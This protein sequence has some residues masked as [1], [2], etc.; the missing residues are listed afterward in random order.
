M[1]VVPVHD[2]PKPPD[3]KLRLVVDHSAGPYSL[4]SMI[5]RKSIGGVKFD[6]IKT[7]GDSIRE[8]HASHAD[9]FLSG[10][11]LTLW[12]SDVAAVYQQ[13][14]MY[15]LWQIKQVINI[16]DKFSVD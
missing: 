11:P 4:N 13:M 3:N 16:D 15:P 5:D 7:L 9:E 2:V 6:G 12:K 10:T 14:P 8:F 1:N